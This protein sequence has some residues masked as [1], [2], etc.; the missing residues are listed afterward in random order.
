M[1]IGL[2]P[3]NLVFPDADLIIDFAQQAEQAGVE[4]LWTFEHV[5]VPMDYESKYPYDKSGKMGATPETNFVDPL[6][7]LAAIAAATSTIRLGTGVNILSQSNPMFIAKQAASLDFMSKGRFMLGVGIGWLEEEFRAMGVPFERRGAR[8]DDYVQAMRKAWSGEVVEHQSDFIDW[9]GFK[10]YPLP[11]QSPMPVVIGGAQGKVYERIAKYGNGWYA[12]TKSPED[13]ASR[14]DELKAVCATEGR[15]YGE[16]EITAM[17][18]MRGGLDELK[19]YA[20]L[21][22]HRLNVPLAAMREANPVDGLGKLHDEVLS[23]LG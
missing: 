12:P 1:K 5:V 13:L 18:T 11:V 15:D 10:S 22:V 7:C 8:F 14:L 20:D 2:I 4:S 3:V 6:V 23:K 16:I 19:A 9:S 21:G 17:W